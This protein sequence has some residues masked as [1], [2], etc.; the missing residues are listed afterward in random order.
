[1]GTEYPM[2]KLCCFDLDGCLCETPNAHYY[3]FKRAVES[4]T[5]IAITKKQH[6][7][8]YNGLSTKLKLKKLKEIY[9]WDDQTCTQIWNLKQSLTAEYLD[10]LETDPDKIEMIK[11]LK[12]KGYKIACVSNCIRDSVNYILNKI[13]LLDLFDLTLSNEDVANPKPSPEIYMRAMIHFNVGSDETIII[14][15]S[16]LGFQA[17]NL[18]NAHVLRVVGPKDVNL[19]NIERHINKCQGKKM[20][21]PYENYELNVV[22]PCAGMGSRF[23]ERGYSFIKPLI[24]VAGKTMIERVIESLNIKANYIFIVQKSHAEKYNLES[25]FQ[26]VSPGS[27]M[28]TVDGLTEGAACTILTAKN[29]IGNNKIFLI[30]Y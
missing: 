16:S 5:G 6:D 25:F 4:I 3:S 22:V 13:G 17:A 2:I 21:Q 15:D 23:A 9:N 26:I 29:L 11:A 28:L 30:Y 14:E 12:D 7:L 10:F 18:T 1:M 20:N 24:D 8:D 27:K 19:Y